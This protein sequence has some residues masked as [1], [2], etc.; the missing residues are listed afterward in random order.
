MRRRSLVVNFFS[1][2]RDSIIFLLFCQLVLRHVYVFV[3][4]GCFFFVFDVFE[5]SLEFVA[6]SSLQWQ[7]RT[8]T[9]PVVER[10][11]KDVLECTRN[12]KPGKRQSRILICQ[13][14]HLLRTS[15]SWRPSGL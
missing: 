7:A 15:S 6:F 3:Y 4:L 11:Q 5:W 2:W 10:L 12:P 9:L 14:D 1:Q 8:K 13:S